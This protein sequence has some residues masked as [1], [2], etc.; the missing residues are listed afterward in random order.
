MDNSLNDKGYSKH[1]CCSKKVFKM[2]TEDCVN[3]FLEYN[4][5]FKGMKITQNFILLKIAE[6]YLK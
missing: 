2:V 3:E 4:K 5:D 6:H 1:L